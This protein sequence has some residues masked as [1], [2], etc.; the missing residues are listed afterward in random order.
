MQ[1]IIKELN[2]LKNSEKAK[3]LQRFF[4]TGKG[5]YAEGDVFWG[6]TVPQIR[7][8]CKKYTLTLDEI[9]KLLESKVHEVRFAGLVCLRQGYR[10]ESKE[11]REKIFNFYLKNTKYINNWDLV[12]T[13]APYIF[14]DYLLK[15]KKERL[16]SPKAIANQRKILYKLVKSKNLWER[17]IAVLATFAL[18]K[19]RNFEDLEK[20]SILLLNDN[21]DL[22]H[23]AVGWM[24]REAGKRNMDFL[25]NFLEKYYNQ[26]P[27]T[28]LRYSIEKLDLKKRK[29][30][31]NK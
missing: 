11:Y 7:K 22:I 19:Q 12:D 8:I 17:R 24:L 6:I 2:N 27:R 18:L 9:Q 5:E 23:K 15:N 1:K 10:V 25:I 16:L 31:L 13:S 4:K 21:H 29:K 26:M 3:I 30:F 28:M 14:E 20:I